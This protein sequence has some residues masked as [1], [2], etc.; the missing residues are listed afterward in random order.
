MADLVLVR[1]KKTRSANARREL[2]KQLR[3]AALAALP[4]RDR[5]HDVGTVSNSRFKVRVRGSEG[6]VDGDGALFDLDDPDMRVM[7]VIY[8]VAK[9]GDMVMVDS[10]GP[11]YTILFDGAQ[12]DSLPAE[13]RKPRP[14]VCK[15][16]LDLARMVGAST[17]VVKPPVTA[18]H[19]KY[20]WSTDHQRRS[21]G[22]LPGVWENPQEPV[23]FVQ[24]APDED[25]DPSLMMRRFDKTTYMPWKKAKKP[26]PSAGRSRRRTF[27]SGCPVARCSC[28]GR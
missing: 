21:A 15:S 25:G 3:A 28:R 13:F 7:S 22:R 16:T 23:L 12:L 8:E 6:V 26:I 1:F 20:Q 5:Q 24:M 2:V 14:A 17:K 27:S 19:Q 10:G 9:A 4:H 11:T 18:H